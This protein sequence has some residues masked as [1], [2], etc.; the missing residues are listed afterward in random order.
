MSEPSSLNSVPLCCV[1][2]SF[3]EEL[4]CY[5]GTHR[6]G[7]EILTIRRTILFNYVSPPKR[8]RLGAHYSADHDYMWED[9]SNDQDQNY[10]LEHG[11]FAPFLWSNAVWS[12][13]DDW[14]DPDLMTPHGPRGKMDWTMKL[15]DG[16]R[17]FHTAT[18]VGHRMVRNLEILC[19]ASRSRPSFRITVVRAGYHY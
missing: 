14:R 12:P 5:G 16:E 2:S 10:K 9:G 19:R 15:P 13:F 18:V 1:C 8:P 11:Q 7:P 6:N 17:F 4:I 3:A